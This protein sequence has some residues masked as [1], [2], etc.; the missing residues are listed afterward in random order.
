MAI[1]INGVQYSSA[2]L[3]GQKYSGYLNGQK[4]F[5]TPSASYTFVD[6]AFSTQYPLSRAVSSSTPGYVLVTGRIKMNG[7][8]SWPFVGQQDMV[9]TEKTT[10][11]ADHTCYVYRTDM[12]SWQG[13]VSTG[14]ILNWGTSIPAGSQF[15][16]DASGN[17]QI[18][19]TIPS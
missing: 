19:D 1:F 7:E 3:N 6:C 2:Y 17:V 11:I 14:E 9:W 15:V 10:T 12:Q 5:G 18:F 16:C 13:S 8:D 4:V